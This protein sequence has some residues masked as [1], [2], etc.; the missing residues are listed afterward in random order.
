MKWHPSNR[1]VS[2]NS[3]LL[4][5]SAFVL[6]AGLIQPASSQELEEVVVTASKRGAVVAQDLAMS[7]TAYNQER[8]EAMGVQE[9]TDFSRMVA[10][11][12]VVDFGPSEKRYMIRGLN[13]PGEATVGVYYDNVPVLGTG[14]G[15]GGFGGAQA[16]FDLFDTERVEVLRGPQ[17][18]LYGANSVNG[19]VRVISN[20]PETSGTYGSVFLNAAAKKDG[21]PDWGAKAMINFPLGESFAARL[22][23]YTTEIG[24]F[25]DNNQLRKDPGC[26]APQAPNPEVVLID[27][28]GCNDGSINF[29]DTNGSTRDGARLQFLWDINERSTLLLQGTYQDTH[30]DGR[31]GADP[32]GAINAGPP[33]VRPVRGG[34]NLVISEAAGERISTIKTL[35]ENDDEVT[36]LTLSYRNEFDW[37]ELNVSASN[38][39][40]DRFNV[41]DSSNAARLHRSFK[42][43][44]FPPPIRGGV[45][46]PTDRLPFVVDTSTDVTT[47]E[48]RL[49][50]SFDGPVNFLAGL[51]YQDVDRTSD[52][53]GLSAD[54]ASGEILTNAQVL[55]V[56]IPSD[57]ALVASYPWYR[58]GTEPFNV[59][60]RTGVNSTEIKAIYGEAYWN[61][62]EQFELMGGLRYF[63]TDITSE[64][65]IIVPFNNSPGIQGSPPGTFAS[66]PANETD[67]LFKAQATWRFNED[68]QVYFQVAEGYRAGGVNAQIVSTI[69]AQFESDQTFNLELGVKASWMDGRLLT[70]LYLFQ[71]DWDNV[72]FDAQFTQQF[73]GL[74]NCTEQSD[75]VQSKGFEIT[76]HYQATDNLDLGVDFI[77]LDADWQVD[78]L[79]C[80][81]PEIVPDL[82]DPTDLSKAGVSLLGVPDYSGSAFAQYN[83]SN[84]ILGGD[85]GFIRL[86]VAFQGKVTQNDINEAI[87]LPSP[88]YQLVNLNTGLD[89]GNFGVQLYV[90]NLFDE[91]AW[92]ALRQGFQTANRV[93]PSQP[94]TIGFNLTYS[95]G[96]N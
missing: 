82:F 72:Q 60:H 62:T 96:E 32:I 9:F 55:A 50:S 49:A 15:P 40:R 52:S 33:F 35:E 59:T 22:V 31:T 57:R 47:F 71:T 75:A 25:I 69:P 91:K 45:V 61:I 74:L 28:P 76:A 37:G 64:E 70:N 88:S 89:F 65:T 48:A 90:R 42:A 86:D 44:A 81:S 54:P 2:L 43:A 38:F 36:I 92:F 16:D 27:A 41:L 79:S 26:Y 77:S 93:T 51:F 85:N 11:L 94:R 4:S 80:V 30:T 66:E 46:S 73:T 63:E 13:L 1:S 3:F 17:G 83:F 68:A 7:I 8:L 56:M 34:S 95:F 78:A 6:Y 29:E 19:V 58:N 20:K 14:N 39:E 10:G 21:E 87:N 12:D 5:L 84:T 23:A 18:T 53:I 24:G 67:T